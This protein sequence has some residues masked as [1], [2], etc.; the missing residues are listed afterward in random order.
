MPAWFHL[1]RYYCG[2]RRPAISTAPSCCT[3]SHERARAGWLLTEL[4]DNITMLAICREL[5]FTIL[6]DPTDPNL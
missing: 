1:T 6:G 2:R 3:S 5:G 4:R